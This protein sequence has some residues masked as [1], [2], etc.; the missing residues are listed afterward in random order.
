MAAAA[1]CCMMTVVMSLSSCTDA[2]DNPSVPSDLQ[3][4]LAPDAKTDVVLDDVICG[5]GEFTLK[6]VPSVTTEEIT[7]DDF[8]FEI[9]EDPIEVGGSCEIPG[10][11]L[12]TELKLKHV[13]FYDGIWWAYF[14]Y[15]A[16][17]FTAALKST[18]NVMFRGT[19]VATVNV[20]YNKP[21]EVEINTLDGYLY[22]GQTYTA[23]LFDYST[24]QPFEGLWFLGQSSFTVNL[25]EPFDFHKKDYSIEDYDVV[26]P[27]DFPFSDA[28]KE[29]GFA[30]IALGVLADGG[31]TS[32]LFH[33]KYQEPLKAVATSWDYY[34]FVEPLEDYEDDVV[35]LVD[36]YIISP[37]NNNVPEESDCMFQFVD[38]I[39]TKNIINLLPAEGTISLKTILKD[40]YPPKDSYTIGYHYK[41][42]IQSKS[43]DD[44]VVD[45]KT[46]EANTA[47]T[48]PA[49]Y[50][51][52]EYPQ[53]LDFKYNIDKDGRI[54]IESSDWHK[55]K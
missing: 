12:G 31:M 8:S 5:S 2:E 54:S 24:D 14:T 48:T 1:L 39:A 17:A 19:Q 40:E 28:E 25:V 52:S 35:N 29:Q 16:P 18:V 6:F 38:N 50:L 9:D 44:E 43:A 51:N 53:S 15:Y 10:E 26:I 30:T 13:D 32:T 36:T 46:F 21:Y 4:V 23:T 34:F 55:I 33:V 45:T 37:N 7:V 42:V 49:E 22:P 20:T 3:L 47:V 11:P 41:L 27:E